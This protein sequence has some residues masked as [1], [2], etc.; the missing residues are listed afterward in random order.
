MTIVEVKKK[1]VN[2]EISC[3]KLVE[4]YLNRIKEVDGGEKGINAV[5][6]LNEKDA[7]EKAVVVDKKIKKGDTLGLLEGVPIAIKDII[8]TN[9][10]KTTAASKILDNFVPTYDATAVKNLKKAGAIIIAKTNCDEFAHGASGENSAYGVTRNP[11]DLDKVPGGSSSGS[12][13]IVAYGG[14]TAALGTDTGGSTRL[15]ASFLGLV[16]LKPTYGRVSRRGLIAMCS[17][18]DSIA[19]ITENV[20]DAAI[21]L[22]IISNKD[23]QDSTS[24][25][26]AGKDFTRDFNKGIKGLKIAYPKEALLEGLDEKVKKV[27]FENLEMLKAEGAKISPISLPL[28]GEP[29]VAVYYIIVPSEISSNLARFDGVGY[30]MRENLAK[31]LKD[32]YSKTRTK[33]LGK[34][35]KRRIMLGNFSLSAGYF[36]AYY[37]KAQKV[38]RLIKEE[39]QKAFEK[40]DLIVTPTTTT[41]PFKIGEKADPLAMY[42]VDIYSAYANLAGICAISVNGGWVDNNSKAE[43]IF[44]GKKK[45][46]IGF[47]FMAKQWDEET[48]LRVAHHFEKLVSKNNK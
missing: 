25:G 34:E 14:A 27:F 15:P 32:F 35:V 48:L 24:S 6:T 3:E 38:R 21:L 1:L 39:A 41:P 44:P 40:Y 11:Y 43:S 26:F 4:D 47:Q 45:L 37:N 18:I 8:C 5:I 30:G 19:P 33:Y 10:L 17:S 16:G 36:D 29:A 13:A 22:S 31:D 7:R 28:F 20:S 9:N 12:G 23:P 46:P 42:L 2:G